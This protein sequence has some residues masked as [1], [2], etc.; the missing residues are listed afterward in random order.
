M[1]SENFTLSSINKGQLKDGA[2]NTVDCSMLGGNLIK[3]HQVDCM[4]SA[5][6][7]TVKLLKMTKNKLHI[8]EMR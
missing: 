3:S 4:F 8:V 6:I 5:L 7:P 2:I 1:L